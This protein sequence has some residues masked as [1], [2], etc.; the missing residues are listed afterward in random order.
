MSEHVYETKLVSQNGWEIHFPINDAS[1][2]EEIIRCRDCKEYH[3]PSG[4]CSQWSTYEAD[5]FTDDNGYCYM[6]HKR[7]D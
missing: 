4:L 6:A 1:P 3:E 7:V 2:K 5:V